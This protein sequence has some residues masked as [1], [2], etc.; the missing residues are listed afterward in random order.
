[1]F[2]PSCRILRND[3]IIVWNSFHPVVDV[4]ISGVFVLAGHTSLVY[5]CG[6]EVLRSKKCQILEIPSISFC[7]SEH[8]R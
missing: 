3:L 5:G 2:F 6:M 1:M 7:R 4:G 8:A